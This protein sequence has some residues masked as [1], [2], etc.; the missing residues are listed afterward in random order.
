MRTINARAI[1]R[2]IDYRSVY[3]GLMLQRFRSKGVVMIN[4]V[5]ENR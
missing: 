4:A 1:H 2:A 3:S 5:P